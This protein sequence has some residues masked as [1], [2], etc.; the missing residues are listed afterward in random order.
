MSME[1]V[2]ERI[3]ADSFLQASEIISSAK[4]KAEEILSLAAVEAAV[5]ESRVRETARRETAS[6]VAQILAQGRM[7]ARE[8]TR[9]ARDGVMTRC[10]A[11]AQQ[12]LQKIP[13]TPVYP[14]ILERLMIEGIDLVGGDEVSLLVNQRDRPIIESVAK[15]F[16][17]QKPLI[18]I[19]NQPI[20]SGAGIIIKSSSGKISVDNTFDARLLRMKK[21]LV[22]HVA[23]ILFRQRRSPK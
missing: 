6:R 5:E 21:D 4:K 13:A 23:E 22:F 14:V 9:S 18:R 15:R 10:F 7:E 8:I 17:R 16:N 20:D 2:I 19:S 1:K 3:N 11:M 12:E